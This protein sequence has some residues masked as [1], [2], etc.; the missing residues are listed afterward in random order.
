MERFITEAN[1][2][3]LAASLTEKIKV[4]LNPSA[5]HYDKLRVLNS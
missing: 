3:K 4:S 1:L 2:Q 5:Q